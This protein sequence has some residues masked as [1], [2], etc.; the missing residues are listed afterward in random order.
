MP[1]PMMDIRHVV[2][3]VFLGRMFML[4]CMD[5]APAVVPVHGVIMA[6]AVLMED[7]RVHVRMGMVFIDEQQRAADH[8]DSRNDKEE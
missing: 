4:M 3:F 8:Q 6:V 1:M 2:M 5:S 7:D